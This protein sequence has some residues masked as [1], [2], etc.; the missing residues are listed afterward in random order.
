ME[1]KLEQEKLQIITLD[2][3]SVIWL[4]KD[5]EILINGEP[6]DVKSITRKGNSIIV[7]G[8]YDVEEKKLKNQLEA[9]HHSKDKAASAN[10]SLLLFFFTTYCHTNEPINLNPPFFV[11]KKQAQQKKVDKTC[12]L[13][14]DIIIPPP[15]CI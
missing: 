4:K 3:A 13:Y 2:A 14:N 15:R 5:K 1:E 8:L 12:K 6:F 11:Y 10:N 7:S 9:Y